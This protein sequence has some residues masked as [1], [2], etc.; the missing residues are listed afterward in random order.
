MAL[1]LAEAGVAVVAAGHIA[2]DLAPFEA[3]LAARRCGRAAGFV[4][5]PPATLASVGAGAWD[6][7]ERS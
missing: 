3:A 5:H 1:G 2:A 4:L 6:G 7:W